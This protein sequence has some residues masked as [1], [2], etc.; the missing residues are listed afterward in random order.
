LLSAFIFPDE[1]IQIGIH[2]Q[3]GTILP[4]E[5]EF[6]DEKGNIVK[7]GELINKPT[8]LA[9][10]Y[11]NCPA[12]CNPLLFELSNVVNKTDL[13]LGYDYNI[14]CISFDELE[15]PEIAN[16][17]KQTFYS[18][19]DA[20]VSDVS[21]RFLTGDSADIKK[22]SDAAGFYFKREGKEFRHAGALIFVDEDGKICR[23]LFPGY[24]NNHGFGILPFDFKMAV[25]ETSKGNEI[26]TVARM[27]RFCFSYDTEGK[28]YAFNFTRI[29][30]AGILILAG[31]FLVV[32]KI[33]PKKAFI[34]PR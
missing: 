4:M 17:K 26:P 8:V 33:K 19:L 14:I 3:L 10:V 31:I 34:K 22:A 32:L 18:S 30:G 15:T 28:S 1:K 25:I 6:K 2:E 11:Y 13:E 27:L 12:I 21:W 9:F 16:S 20:D 7:L 23:Y 24:T 29:F 5:T